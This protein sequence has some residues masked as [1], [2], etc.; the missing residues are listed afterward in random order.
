MQN[1]YIAHCIQNIVQPNEYPT[2]I[3]LG[4]DISV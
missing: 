2:Q 4:E 1:T 3:N